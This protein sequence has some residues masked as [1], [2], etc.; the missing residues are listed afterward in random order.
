[1]HAQ[2]EFHIPEDRH[3]EIPQTSKALSPSCRIP[4]TAT[5][6]SFFRRGDGWVS[7]FAVP[8]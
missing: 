3:T 8:F 7:Q 6:Q 5:P 1:M 2:S 4:R